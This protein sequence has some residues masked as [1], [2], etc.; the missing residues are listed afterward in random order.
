MTLIKL[1]YNDNDNKTKKNIYFRQKGIVPF[2][3]VQ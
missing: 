3:F 2:F 1:K